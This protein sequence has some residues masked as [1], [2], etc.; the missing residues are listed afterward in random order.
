M[1]EIIEY[2][3]KVSQNGQMMQ[4]LEAEILPRVI[5][6]V[7]EHMSEFVTAFRDIKQLQIERQVELERLSIDKSINLEKFRLIAETTQQRLS[8]QIENIKEMRQQIIAMH[9]DSPEKQH[10]QELLIQAM[11]QMQNLYFAEMQ[12]FLNM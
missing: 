4:K 11:Q 5:E 8:A 1:D 3:N 10:S 6:N 7:E 2:T 12:T 9:I